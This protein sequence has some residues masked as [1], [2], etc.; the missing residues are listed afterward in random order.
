MCKR[1]P[2]E[3]LLRIGLHNLKALLCKRINCRCI[4][5]NKRKLIERLFVEI[6]ANDMNCQHFTMV[7]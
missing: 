3:G 7:L 1:T 2:A 5:C 4:M 6:I